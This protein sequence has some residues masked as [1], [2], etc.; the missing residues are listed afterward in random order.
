MPT[1]IAMA[2][3]ARLDSVNRKLIRAAVEI[4]AEAGIHLELL[5]LGDFPLPLY[6]GDLEQSA[7]LPENARRLKALFTAADALLIAAPEYNSSVTP[8]LK[9][10]ID[11]VSRS[12]RDDEPELAAYRG[13]AV[14]LLSASPSALG[15]LRGLFHLRDIFQNIGVT[16][17]PSQFAL[18]SAYEKFDEAGRLTDQGARKKIR[19]V[20]AALAEMSAKLSGQGLPSGS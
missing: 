9:N 12:E 16:V 2:G 19:E 6:D 11:W 20:V 10:T 1:I 7:G 15:G 13:K 4:A 18:G 8:L 5:E 17:V 14:G 3:S